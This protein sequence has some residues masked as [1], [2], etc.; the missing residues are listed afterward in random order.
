M[1]TFIISA[2][3]IIFLLGFLILIHEAGHL[4][5][6]K[7]CKVK[8][9]EF[10]IGFGPTILK[11]QGKE[12]KYAL[13][14]IPLG[15]FCNMEGEEE[16]SKEKGSFSEASI[17]RRIAIVL[18]GA[19][20]NIIF[21]LLVFFILMACTGNYVTNTIDSTIEGYVAQEINLQ[22][23]D[24]II[25]INDTKINS[26]YDLDNV[27]ENMSGNQITLNIERNGE[28]LEYK[29]NPTKVES[30]YTDVIEDET[31][32]MYIEAEVT[33]VEPEE[34]EL[35]NEEKIAYILEEYDLTMDQF[36]VIAAIILAEAQANNYD[37]A[38]DIV[39]A[40]Y[41]RTWSKRW[42]GYIEGLMNCDTG[43]NLYTQA[44][45]LSQFEV[46]T[47]GGYL[48]F[49]NNS[50]D[51]VGYQ[52]VIDM[53]YSQESHHNFM[54]FYADPNEPNGTHFHDVL[55]DEDRI[56]LENSR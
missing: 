53:L 16:R 21:G 4:L 51:L 10:A 3:K 25:K 15:G 26:K 47:N 1:I 55:T 18:A 39:N 56:V 17:P 41:N 36:N 5:V 54:S 6:A 31:K 34:K 48:Q 32:P 30:K 11:K 14:L 44:T 40:L 52:A 49:L 24:K 29:I 28:I 37:G 45:A 27:M 12:T 23:D 46:Y 50:S 13:R 38:Y 19:T 9:N 2:V 7:L 33:R 8:V 35:T 42:V 20:V 22:K 43:R